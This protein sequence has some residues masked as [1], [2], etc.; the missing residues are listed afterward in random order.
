MT[1]RATTLSHANLKV[2]RLTCFF[3]LLLLLA[4][5]RG[6]LELI[7]AKKFAMIF[8]FGGLMAFSAVLFSPHPFIITSKQKWLLAMILL[9]M[10]ESFISCITTF[11]KNQT[12]IWVVYITFNAGLLGIALV[13][14]RDFRPKELARG[15]ALIILLIG[16]VLM[17]VGV[18]EQTRLI[19]MVGSGDMYLIRPA[20]LTGSFLHYPILMAL[21]GY[22]CIQ[23]YTL[24][25]KTLYLWSGFLFCF[26]TIIS[27]SRSG[28]LI[29]LATIFFYPLVSP[30]KKS[31]RILCILFLFI[32]FLVF[33]FTTYTKESRN[34]LF[35][36]IVYRVVSSVNTKSLGNNV[37]I[38][39]WDR[40]TTEW[41]DTNLLI[42][43]EAGEYTNSSNNLRAKKQMNMNIS[44]VTESSVL[45]LLMNFGILGMV[46]F[47]GILFQI[48]RFIEPEHYWM[49]A[50]FLG[51]MVQTL[52]YQSIEV[53]PF[54]VLLFLFPWISQSL[55]AQTEIKI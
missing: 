8:Q 13:T 2:D 12:F 9:F 32:L 46:L 34:S 54:I 28:A 26:S 30:L 10:T 6:V 47:Y 14:V 52:V 20:S 49:R 24:S 18:I 29:V 38:N 5:S 42:G 27:F 25:K 7:V 1:L 33:A 3:F 53:V 37:R 22:I 39:I 17:G 41:L 45:Q 40:V 23:W 21:L 35:H 48:M 4:V 16:W 11:Y 50:V 43:E 44:K 51:A 36:N 55:K 15:I 31:K 19:K